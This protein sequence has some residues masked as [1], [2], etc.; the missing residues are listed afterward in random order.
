MSRWF[1]AV[2]VSVGTVAMISWCAGSVAPRAMRGLI[3]LTAT[4]QLVGT[5]DK[6]K[7]A[8]VRLSDSEQRSASQSRRDWRRRYTSGLAT[9]PPIILLDEATM[10]LVVEAAWMW[11]RPAP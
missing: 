10:G 3:L 6:K 1:D 9:D 7:V 2:V 8:R 4:R 11:R 5:W